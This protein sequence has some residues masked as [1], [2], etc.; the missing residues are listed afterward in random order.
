M[1]KRVFAWVLLVLFVLLLVNLIV[2]RWQWQLSIAVYAVILVA[3]VFT[4]KKPEKYKD[5]EPDSA[6]DGTGSN[7]EDAE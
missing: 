2:I 1:K 6:D 7:E 3:F 4:A 5:S